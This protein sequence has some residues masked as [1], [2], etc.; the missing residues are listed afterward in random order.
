LIEFKEEQ[1][2]EVNNLRSQI[3]GGWCEVGDPCDFAYVPK[4][5]KNRQKGI[6]PK[7]QPIRKMSRQI[8]TS[9]TQQ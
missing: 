9:T 8:A 6:V 4:I 1:P 5:I 3:D 2:Q 7:K